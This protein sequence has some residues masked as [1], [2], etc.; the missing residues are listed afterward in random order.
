METL[1]L[2]RESREK[3]PIKIILPVPKSL[4]LFY[5]SAKG[6]LTGGTN[7]AVVAFF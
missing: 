4:S 5:C 2:V 1:L 3:S 7:S 6:M